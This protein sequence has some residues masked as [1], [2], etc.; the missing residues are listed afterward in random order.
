MLEPEWK[1]MSV[2]YFKTH[3]NDGTVPADLPFEFPDLFAAVEEAK[4]VLAEMALDG[5]PQAPGRKLSIE[6]QNGER[7]PIVN[8][9][10]EL[11]ID[12]LLQR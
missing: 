8:L 12:Y 10:L 2:F 11:K 5:L 9:Q 6:V 4:H 1:P 7:L 3:D